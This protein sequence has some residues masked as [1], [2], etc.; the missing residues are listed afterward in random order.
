DA[1]LMRQAQ[2]ARIA[3]ELVGIDEQALHILGGDLNA[4]PGSDEMRFLRG[5]CS[6]S[7]TS[8]HMQDAWLR[9]HPEDARGNTWSMQRGTARA[10]R[11]IDVDRRI[12]YIY[13]GTR[14]AD[15]RGTVEDCGK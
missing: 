9:H 6:L 14:R 11:S 2:V 15:G 8:T 13:V 3:A 5:L 10:T 7:A 4:E 1:C 12:D